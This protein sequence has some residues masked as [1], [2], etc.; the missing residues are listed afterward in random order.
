MSTNFIVPTLKHCADFD[1]TNV[2]FAAKKAICAILMA[3]FT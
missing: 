2:E 1:D 3:P